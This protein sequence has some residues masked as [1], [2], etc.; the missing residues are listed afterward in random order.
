M[1]KRSIGENINE[2]LKS[3]F[4]IWQHRYDTEKKI[5]LELEK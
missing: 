3:T 4:E 1:P 2:N 5:K